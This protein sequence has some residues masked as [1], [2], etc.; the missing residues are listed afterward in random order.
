MIINNHHPTLSSYIITLHYHPLLCALWFSNRR[1]WIFLLIVVW[2]SSHSKVPK[3]NF[4]H[5][6]VLLFLSPLS[7]K[8]NQK[9]LLLLLLPLTFLGMAFWYKLQAALVADDGENLATKL[10][11]PPFLTSFSS[12][13]WFP[14]PSKSSRLV[15]RLHHHHGKS[16]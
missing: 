3:C 7:Q 2:T 5:L 16:T 6:L 12:C 14:G 9:W 4:C 10:P 8:T 11:C 15:S 13:V 1:L